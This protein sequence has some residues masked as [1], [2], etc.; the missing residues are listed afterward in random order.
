MGRDYDAESS[1]RCITCCAG[2][3]APQ[4]SQSLRTKFSLLAAT[5]AALCLRQCSRVIAV[6]V[7]GPAKAQREM[8]FAMLSI[9]RRQQQP[10]SVHS[11]RSHNFRWN[12]SNRGV[13][14]YSNTALSVVE[15]EI[16]ETAKGTRRRRRPPCLNL[17]IP[18][19]AGT[20]IFSSCPLKQMHR[21]PCA[22][23]SLSSIANQRRERQKWICNSFPLR[24]LADCTY[25]NNHEHFTFLLGTARSGHKTCFQY[26]KMEQ[27]APIKA[28]GY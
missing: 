21:R 1:A 9:A 14:E 10:V 27:H 24:A 16:I 23:L 2:C 22:M 4:I 11:T 7:V 13:S 5:S 19:S 3:S 28:I 8:R 15:P 17:R 6:V 25:D 26:C 12:H 20:D 18:C